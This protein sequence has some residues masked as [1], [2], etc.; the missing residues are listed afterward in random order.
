MIGPPL[1]KLVALLAPLS[2]VLLVFADEGIS[3]SPAVGPGSIAALVLGGAVAWYSRNAV[4]AWKEAAQGKDVI[5]KD[6]H[7]R[8]EELLGGFSREKTELLRLLSVE[9]EAR[10]SAEQRPDLGSVVA[11]LDRMAHTVETQAQA[12]HEIG[13]RL[14]EAQ[15]QVRKLLTAHH[16]VAKQMGETVLGLRDGQKRLFEFFDLMAARERRFR[17]D[18]KEGGDS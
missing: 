4:K 12:G 13:I 11:L 1:A 5:I 15:E 8:I 10:A 14:L 3:Y 6:L 18:D 16:E 7:A 17:R 9:R 2:L